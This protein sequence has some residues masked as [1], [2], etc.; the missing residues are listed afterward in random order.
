MADEQ[1]PGAVPND[2]PVGGAAGPE[3]DNAPTR[4]LGSGGDDDADDG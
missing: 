3:D 2:Q 4:P 1:R